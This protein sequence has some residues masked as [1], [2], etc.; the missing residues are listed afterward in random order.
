MRGLIFIDSIRRYT[1][2]GV[3]SCPMNG[4]FLDSSDVPG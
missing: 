1:I 4:C 2:A 3:F